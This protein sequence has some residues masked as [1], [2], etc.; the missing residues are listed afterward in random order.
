MRE[1]RDR[2]RLSCR[3]KQSTLKCKSKEKIHISDLIQVASI[4]RTTE[5]LERNQETTEKPVLF[6]E[7]SPI[8]F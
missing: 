1:L 5:E 3:I 6:F 2:Y 4:L 7:K 8:T